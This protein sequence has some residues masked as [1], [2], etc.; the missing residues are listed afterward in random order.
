MKEIEDILIQIQ[1]AKEQKLESLLFRLCDIVKEYEGE[2]I[3]RPI[4][5]ALP[6]LATYLLY[7]E[8]Y[9]VSGCMLSIF[10]RVTISSETIKVLI[11]L[12]KKKINAEIIHALSQVE[13]AMWNTDIELELVKGLDIEETAYN[14][15][16]GLYQKSDVILHT[17]T[18]EKIASVAMST[19]YLAAQ[20]AITTL[21]CLTKYTHRDIALK[22]LHNILEVSDSRIRQK[23][24]KTLRWSTDQGLELLKI[25]ATDKDAMVRCATATSLILNYMESPDAISIVENLKNDKNEDVRKAVSD[26][27]RKKEEQLD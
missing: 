14:A 10:R 27:F 8:K 5:D 23:I 11:A 21:C 17:K 26:G 19:D 20:L 12:H 1:P 2:E 25:T 13:R 22:K 9:A 15:V 4:E 16:S 18:V 3:L 6:E 7:D 24:T